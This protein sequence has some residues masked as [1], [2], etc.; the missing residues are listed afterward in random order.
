[1]SYSKQHIKRRLQ[2][3]ERKKHGYKSYVD[4]VEDYS[5]A[6]R[7]DTG[8][9]LFKMIKGI[10]KKLLSQFIG[11]QKDLIPGKRAK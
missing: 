5:L 7:P 8:F 3:R 2:L 6:K 4:R 10:P 1:M 11:S 9:D